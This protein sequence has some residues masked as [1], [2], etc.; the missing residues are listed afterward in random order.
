MLIC[1]THLTRKK[2]ALA[3]I[4]AGAAIIALIMFLGRSPAPTDHSSFQLTTNEER[5]NYI[6]SLGWEVVEEPLET[7]QFLLPSKLSGDYIPYNELQ[8]TQGFDLETC[9]GK[10]IT[11]YTY[12][13]TNYPEHPDGIQLN[14]YICENLVVAGDILCAGSNGFQAPLAF[15]NNTEKS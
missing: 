14:L 15:P 9:C 11:R 6:H 3:V 4:I 2:A 5:I 10:Q 8:K 1:T 7:L 13:V 12:S